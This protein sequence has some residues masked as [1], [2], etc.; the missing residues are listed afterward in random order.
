MLERRT[1][2]HHIMLHFV[3]CYIIPYHIYVCMYVYICIYIFFY[4]LFC[5]VLYDVTFQEEAFGSKSRQ[6]SSSR[7]ASTNSMTQ[8]DTNQYNLM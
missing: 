3:I 1:V 5:I 4:I 8:Y 7:L 2:W 6:G